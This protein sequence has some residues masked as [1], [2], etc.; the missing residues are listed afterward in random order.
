MMI[1]LGGKAFGFSHL[2]PS[3]GRSG[4]R[5][6]KEERHEPIRNKATVSYALWTL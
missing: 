4:I 1:G 3:N 5:I 6:T 2:C